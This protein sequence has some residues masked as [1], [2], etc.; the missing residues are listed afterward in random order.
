MTPDNVSGEEEESDHGSG[1]PA[2]PGPSRSRTNTPRPAKGDLRDIPCLQCGKFSSS[3]FG[4]RAN[5]S[6]Q[7]CSSW[8]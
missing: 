1:K 3:P 6:S 8:S 4:E 7:S 5:C 2:V